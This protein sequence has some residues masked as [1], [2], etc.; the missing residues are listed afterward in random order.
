L[1]A[2]EII[3]AE[4]DMLLLN[5]GVKIRLDIENLFV[6]NDCLYQ[7][8]GC[9]RIKLTD[10]VML[11]LSDRITYEN[12]EYFFQ[13]GQVRISIPQGIAKAESK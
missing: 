2:I 3:E 5:T 1:F 6:E 8:D 7:R 4:N 10:R 13:S 12:D 9:W 11:K